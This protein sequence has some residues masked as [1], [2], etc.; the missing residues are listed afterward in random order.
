M[1]C[2]LFTLYCLSVSAAATHDTTTPAALNMAPVAL[3]GRFATG[4]ALLG[5][6]MPMVESSFD[7][8]KEL[9]YC[10]L[11]KFQLAHD[12]DR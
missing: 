11:K 1:W 2:L 4:L 7:H 5:P 9:G 8:D 3:Q 6:R 10:I 12:G